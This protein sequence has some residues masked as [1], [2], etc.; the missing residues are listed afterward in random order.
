[1]CGTFRHARTR[2]PGQNNLARSVAPPCIGY[3]SVAPPREFEHTNDRRRV[4]LCGACAACSQACIPSPTFLRA[5][6][7]SVVVADSR[8]AGRQIARGDA[9]T[10]WRGAEEP[11]GQPSSSRFSRLRVSQ[12]QSQR[13]Q[14]RQWE[15]PSARVAFGDP[16]C[17]LVADW[18][19]KKTETG[20]WTTKKGRA[21]R[22]HSPDGRLASC[23]SALRGESVLPASLPGSQAQQGVGDGKYRRA[24]ALPLSIT[25]RCLAR[26]RRRNGTGKRIARGDAEMGTRTKC[27]LLGVSASLREPTG[28]DAAMGRQECLPS[29]WTWRAL[30]PLSAFRFP[31]WPGPPLRASGI[32]LARTAAIWHVLAIPIGASRVQCC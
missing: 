21:R 26:G 9:V 22:R 24:R 1:M 25:L 8:C 7:A 19:G 10:R 11:R 31:L 32:L 20:G 15:T 30:A 5:F 27:G 13:R 18:F 4:P 14:A 12:S 3:S 2:K 29:S 28:I 23:A 16:V 17:F 6:S